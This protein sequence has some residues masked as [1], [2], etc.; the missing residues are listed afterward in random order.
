MNKLVI[1]LTA[2]L[3]IVHSNLLAQGNNSFRYQAVIQHENG[4]IMA[5][6]KISFLVTILKSSLNK[7]RVYAEF[8]TTTTNEFGMVNLAIGKGNPIFKTF[9]GI[10]WASDEHFIKIE[11]DENGGSNFTLLGESQLMTVP[12][13]LHAQTADDVDDADANPENELQTLSLVENE[14]KITRGNSVELPQQ[15]LTLNGNELSISNGNS[16]MLP[17]G[18]SQVPDPEL[19]VPIVFRG[20][21]IYIHPTDNSADIIFGPFLSTGATSDFDGLSNT[22]NLVNAYGSGS[23]AAKVCAD[24]TAF[25]YDDWYLPSRA[26][27]DA[28]FKQN[29][30]I[31]DYTL[32][33]YWT[34]TETAD[35][36][37]YTIDLTTGQLNDLTKNQAKK[38]R[39]VRRE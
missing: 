21:Y 18:D 30:L 3:I 15:T 9:S 37:A 1:A 25:G 11:M 36:K 10:N 16:V 24:L 12:Y 8:H 23:Y 22:V 20:S 29:Y 39:C 34:S 33:Q 28:L 6:R 26:E 38:C 4:E 27:L 2:F 14:L 35:N 32:E 13:A 19:P 5:N 7:E 31:Q 17:T